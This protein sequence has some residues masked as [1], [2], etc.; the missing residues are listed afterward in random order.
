MSNSPSKGIFVSFFVTDVQKWCWAKNGWI[1]SQ[2]Q[3][4]NPFLL[5]RPKGGLF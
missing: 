4:I 5:K 3:K 2:R 1:G